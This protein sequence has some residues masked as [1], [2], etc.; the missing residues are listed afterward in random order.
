MTTSDPSVV[1]AY[2]LT[3]HDILAGIDS[4]LENVVSPDMRGSPY[5]ALFMDELGATLPDDLDAE[6]ASRAHKKG[7]SFVG[8]IVYSRHERNGICHCF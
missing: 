6:W 7:H 2:G 3:K 4:N 8:G 1:T 5:Y